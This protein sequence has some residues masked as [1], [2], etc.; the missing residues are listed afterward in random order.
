MDPNPF[1]P[2]ARGRR[3][4]GESTLLPTMIGT[5]WGQTG[6]IIRTFKKRKSIGR[7]LYPAHTGWTRCSQ[8]RD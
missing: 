3:G 5:D 2:P 1:P 7:K 6:G 4:M 8:N